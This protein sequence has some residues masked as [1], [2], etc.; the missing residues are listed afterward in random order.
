[1]PSTASLGAV[2]A[3]AAPDRLF[4]TRVPHVL[5]R[6]HLHAHFS[7]F[8]ELTDVYLPAAA[9][10]GTA[11]HKGIAFVSF[12]ERASLILAL[13]A[14]PHEI[15]GQPVVVDIA[16]PRGAPRASSLTAVAGG[17]SVVAGAVPQQQQ[18]Q[19]TLVPAPNF[20][21]PQEVYDVAGEGGHFGVLNGML[22]GAVGALGYAGAVSAALGCAGG[23]G[24]DA[25]AAGC[26]GTGFASYPMPRQNVGAPVPGRLFLTRVTPDLGKQELQDYFEQFG[27]LNDCYVPPGGK[28]IAFVSF[29][30]AEVVER[31]LATPQHFLKLGQQPV[32]VEQALERAGAEKG[33]KGK[34]GR[35]AAPY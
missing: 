23:G 29:T 17:Q 35:M 3:M 16:T 24:Y 30:D 32:L 12:A 28:G 5:Q 33:G 21:P 25:A 27:P 26:T 13:E 19:P 10:G 14:A 2:A 6:E 15:G 20:L 1:M 4:V 18:Q 34:V 8:G 7:R 11:P 22:N 9:P 31:V